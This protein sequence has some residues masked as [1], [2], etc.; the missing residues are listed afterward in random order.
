MIL[1]RNG[2]P[3]VV[4]ERKAIGFLDR[5]LPDAEGEPVTMPN[6]VGSRE[7]PDRRRGGGGIGPV[8]E[9]P[10]ARRRPK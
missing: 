2:N 8:H 3:L 9:D 1:D 6:V 4:Y 7:A 5:T 10:F